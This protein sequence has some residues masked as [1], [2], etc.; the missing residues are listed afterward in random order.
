MVCYSAHSEQSLKGPI[1]LS[2]GGGSSFFG[3]L[4]TLFN[5]KPSSIGVFI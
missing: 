4:L 5:V 3:Q 2:G 1:S